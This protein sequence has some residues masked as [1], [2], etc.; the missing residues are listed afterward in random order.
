MTKYTTK[1]LEKLMDSGVEITVPGMPRLR[2]RY[3]ENHVHDYTDPDAKEF[4]VEKDC[5]V[6]C[7]CWCSKIKWSRDKK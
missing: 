2:S 5:Y 4:S 1:Q 3:L 6:P 7:C